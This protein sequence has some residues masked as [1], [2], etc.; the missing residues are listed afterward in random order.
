M[1]SEA[2]ATTE[3]M[4]GRPGAPASGGLPTDLLAPAAVADPYGAF[5]RLRE[6]QPVVWSDR[7]RA[8]LLTS[9]DEV[10]SAS[11]DERMSSDRLTPL[12]G[13]S[14]ERRREVLARTF[15]VLRGWMVFHDEPDH[16]RLREPVKR[17]FT[18]RTVAG[19]R[20]AVERVTTE[21]L[22][23]V[24]E[25]GTCDFKAAVAFPLPAIVIAELLGVPPADRQRFRTW[26]AKL[27]AIVFGASDDPDQ[28]R[29]AAEGSAE[30]ADYFGKLIAE[31][32]REPADD[33]IS[34]LV[35]SRDRGDGLTSEELVG[36]C[37]LLLFAGHE[38]TAN[39][40]ANGV[41][42]LLRSPD[43]LAR[44]RADRTLLPNAVEELLRFEPPQKV[45]VRNVRETHERSGQVLQRGDAAFL[46]V[47]GANRD[48]AEFPDPDRLDLARPTAR[49]HL[50]FGFGA[51]FCLGAALARLEG[52]VALGALLE[53]FDR[54][55]L[56][57]DEREPTWEPMILNRSLATLPLR[58]H[59][60]R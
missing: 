2:T 31:R 60:A 21:L 18:P 20:E 37:T 19:L 10:I 40:I 51:H 36:A 14:S 1:R 49:N 53:R 38:T 28:D 32:E 47:A 6:H 29:A 58:V 41:L 23:D 35:A 3:A 9:Y 59:P 17:A 26:S 45:M 12:E 4:T 7:H 39:L 44:L 42:S 30:F 34:A 56:A 11:R 24:A 50:T 8:W 15:E 52:Q 43:E 54:I 22:D 16:T 5:R 25:A 13:R 55:E 48:P 46:A 27:A 33:L 57:V